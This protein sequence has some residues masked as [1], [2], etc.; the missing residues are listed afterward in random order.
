[1]N[2][3]GSIRAIFVPSITSLNED[4]VNQGR[5]ETM[6]TDHEVKTVSGKRYRI[7]EEGGYF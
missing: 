5:R 7:R 2:K 3:T 1:M 4:T 6:A